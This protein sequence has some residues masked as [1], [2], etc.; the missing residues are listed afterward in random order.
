MFI[1]QIILPINA[2][3][4]FSKKGHALTLSASPRGSHTNVPPYQLLK[5]QILQVVSS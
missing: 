1:L 2:Q 3:L 4:N 5:F